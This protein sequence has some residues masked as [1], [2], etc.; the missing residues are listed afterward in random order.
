MIESGNRIRAGRRISVLRSVFNFDRS[1]GGDGYRIF[2]LLGFW[3]FYVARCECIYVVV[4]PDI[5]LSNRSNIQHA[6]SSSIDMSTAWMM[7]TTE[8]HV[9]RAGKVLQDYAESASSYVRWKRWSSA[10]SS[11]YICLI[12]CSDSSLSGKYIGHCCI[13]SILCCK[14]HG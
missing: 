5:L 11:H 14:W 13:L 4:L 6:S 2:A 7:R 3:A 12:G 9:K 10:D 8:E 1:T